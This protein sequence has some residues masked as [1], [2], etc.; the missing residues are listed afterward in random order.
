MQQLKY[1]FQLNI[2]FFFIMP[3]YRCISLGATNMT[4]FFPL[5]FYFCGFHTCDVTVQRWTS[6]GYIV[7]SICAS[8]CMRHNENLINPQNSHQREKQR[9]DV[10]AKCFR[11]IIPKASMFKQNWKHAHQ[12]PRDSSV[13]Y[14]YTFTLMSLL[15]IIMIII[16]YHIYW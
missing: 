12:S 3:P 4:F 16:I 9:R 10:R 5:W 15:T 14:L 1:M 8:V 13:N 7:C 6:Y 2:E 11:Q